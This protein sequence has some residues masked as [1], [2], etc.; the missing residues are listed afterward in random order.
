MDWGGSV[1]EAKDILCGVDVDRQLMIKEE[2]E[3]NRIYLER[4]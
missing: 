4:E 1:R 2:W 3:S